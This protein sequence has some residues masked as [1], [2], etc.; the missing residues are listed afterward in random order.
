M[1]AAVAGSSEIDGMVNSTYIIFIARKASKVNTV[2]TD[3][4]TAS[5]AASPFRNF[6][7]VSSQLIPK[8]Q[9]TML[10]GSK[11]ANLL[12]IDRLYGHIVFF[13]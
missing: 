6:I 7:Y 9:I 8:I 11:A 2:S 13:Y 10:N 3:V 4:L 12:F 1:A 5:S